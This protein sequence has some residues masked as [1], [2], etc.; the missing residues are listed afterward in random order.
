LQQLVDDL[1]D[2]SKI[3]SG[4]VPLNR[5]PCELELLVDEAFATLASAAREKNV[6]FR[7]EILP[8]TSPV[9]ADG[10]RL[11]LVLANLLGNAFKHSPT[12]ATVTVRAGRVGA[13]TRIEVADQGP[14]IP[15]AYRRLVFDKFFRVP[16]APSGGAGLGL[17]LVK[18]IVQAHGGR[19]GVE[20]G[21][22]EV[23]SVFWLELPAS[24]DEGATA[25]G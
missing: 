10:E 7:A 8:G 5:A 19:L 12:G 24:P 4:R 3:Q 1:L 23:G 13:A 20:P 25:A 2:L 16:G 11:A 14:G 6:T 21:P 9:W 15:A 18:E 22:G 17:Y